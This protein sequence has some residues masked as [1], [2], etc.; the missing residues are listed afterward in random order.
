LEYTE[1]TSKDVLLKQL[2]FLQEKIIVLDKEKKASEE[3]IDILKAENDKHNV[4]KKSLEEK[5]M[6]LENETNTNTNQMSSK[7]IQEISLCSAKNVN[8][9]QKTFTTCGSIFR[10]SF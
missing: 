4:E 8:T 5:I 6:K 1:R 7:L 3:R 9:L 2:S 10:D